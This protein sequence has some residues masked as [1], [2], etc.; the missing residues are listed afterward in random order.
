MENPSVHKIIMYI[1]MT[2]A[3]LIIILFN[4]NDP[5]YVSN[6][7]F[8]ATIIGFVLMCFAFGYGV[9]KHRCPYCKHF[10]PFH[11]GEF[12]Y[13]PYCGANFNNLGYVD[14]D[15]LKKSMSVDEIWKKYSRLSL[16]GGELICISND[17]TEMFKIKYP[18]GLVI[19]VGHI[20]DKY[21]ISVS[22]ADDMKNTIYTAETVNKDD[23]FNEVQKAIRSVRNG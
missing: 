15:F 11:G 18:N 16:M 19:N 10:L 5:I 4:T 8:V 17:G 6:V 22:M 14:D 2:I 9:V 21:C 20:E 12:E 23:L 3:V 7:E 13:C 1:I